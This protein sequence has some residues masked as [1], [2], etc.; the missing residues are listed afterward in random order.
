[1]KYWVASVAAG[2]ALT[3]CGVIPGLGGGTG[4][5]GGTTP[6]PVTS[7]VRVVNAIPDLKVTTD[8]VGAT[9]Y[10]ADVEKSTGPVM[11]GK[12]TDVIKVPVGDQI[13]KVCA[14]GSIKCVESKITVVGGK[15]YTLVATGTQDPADDTATATAPARKAQ[16]LT[17]ENDLA[18]PTGDNFKVRLV[19]AAPVVAADKVDVYLTTT[20][21]SALAGVPVQLDYTKASAYFD[22]PAAAYQVRATAQGAKTN[23][24]IRTAAGVPFEKGKVYTA[25]AANP[26]GAFEGVILLTDK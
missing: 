3:S 16:I 23:V 10:V 1:M 24:L 26:A 8:I 4:G 22:F 21:D 14:A 17:L 7:D 13:V 19:H 6:A 15:S 9:V 20:I 2:L 18:L 11:Y 5:T 12:F 25:I